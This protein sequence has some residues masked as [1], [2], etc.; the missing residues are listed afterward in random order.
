MIKKIFIYSAEIDY[1][2]I[3]RKLE[4]KMSQHH[5]NHGIGKVLIS[6]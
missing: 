6:K 4:V 2:L 1:T 5:D 3:E